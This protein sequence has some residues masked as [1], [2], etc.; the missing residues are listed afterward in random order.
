MAD[1]PAVVV[2]VSLSE[3]GWN[4]SL[5]TAMTNHPISAIDLPFHQW[6]MAIINTL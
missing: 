6:F 4:G 3:G 2:F 5:S 1:G